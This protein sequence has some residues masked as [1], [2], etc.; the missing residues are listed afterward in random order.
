MFDWRCASLLSSITDFS[1]P[2]LCSVSNVIHNYLSGTPSPVVNTFISNFHNHRETFPSRSQA[3]FTCSHFF[4][5]IVLSFLP[6]FFQNHQKQRSYLRLFFQ[7]LMFPS[8]Q[9]SC[10]TQR[11]S[12]SLKI[13]WHFQCWGYPKGFTYDI[14]PFLAVIE[15][16]YFIS[17][18]YLV[19]SSFQMRFNPYCSTSTQRFK[20]FNHRFLY[21]FHSLFSN[22]SLQSKFHLIYFCRSNNS[23]PHFIGSWWFTLSPSFHSE[24]Q[25]SNWSQT[26][27]WKQKSNSPLNF[28]QPHM[29]RVRN[30]DRAH[31]GSVHVALKHLNILY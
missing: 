27:S 17:N 1:R 6:S 20:Y 4:S 30:K 24:R 8:F 14:P 23:K 13:P 22:A 21:R 2:K 18:T 15:Q 28:H 10:G 26:I 16:R 31:K 25:K 3:Y 7:F 9:S 11:R 29:H 19:L 12:P 5:F